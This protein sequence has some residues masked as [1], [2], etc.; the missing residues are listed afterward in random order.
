MKTILILV[1]LFALC[2]CGTF[3][4]VMDVSTVPKET[5]QQ[6]Y[7]VKVFETNSTTNYP[8]ITE[9]IGSITAYSCKHMLYDP[10]ASKGDALIQLRLKA[11][12]KSADGIID[13]TYDSRGTD[14]WGTN[15]WETVQASGV[16]VKFKK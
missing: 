2:G 16:A 6:A 7:R 5:M 9:Y 10:P 8:E 1:T 3:V 11:L 14:T 13:L 15:C 4:P 12:E